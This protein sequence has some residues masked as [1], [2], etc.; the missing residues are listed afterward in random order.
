MLGSEVVQSEDL[1]K[2]LRNRPF[3]PFRLYLT[4]GSAY[5]VRHPELMMLGRRMAVVGLASDPAETIFDRSVDIDLFHIVR[6][7]F[8]EAPAGPNGP[9]GQPQSPTG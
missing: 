6:T 1:E 7:E 4:D 5:D 8:I 9:A 3:R 2:K